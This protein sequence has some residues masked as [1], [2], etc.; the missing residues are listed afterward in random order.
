MKLNSDQLSA[1]GTVCRLKS[2]S[3]A[4]AASGLTQAAFSIRL[5]KLEEA[6]GSTLLI[7]NRGG[8]TLTEEGQKLLNYVESIS[9]LEDECLED[10]S[11]TSVNKLS[12]SLR[13]GTFST[14]GRSHV[15]PAIG[16]L[17]QSHPVNFHFFIK[18]LRELPSMLVSGEAD[19][20]FLDHELKR[21]GVKSVLLGHERYVYVAK[22]GLKK[23]NEIYLNHDEDDLMSYRYLEALGQ[24]N[25]EIKRRF[26]DEIF[27]VIDGVAAGIGVSVIPEH[28][29]KKNPKI[30]IVNPSKGILSPVYLCYKDRPLKSRL[31]KE[32]LQVLLET[33]KA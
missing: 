27:S 3:K 25:I 14:I 11:S 32:A 6:T 7:R 18:E 5:Q 17:L 9:E 19:F 33:W 12:G 2:I 20:I 26:V 31:F 24:K 22:K 16:P 21:D 4:A 28:L 10:L 23:F 13:I 15:L 30:Q 8:M 1:F 29:V